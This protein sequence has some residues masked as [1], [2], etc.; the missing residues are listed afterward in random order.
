MA[1]ADKQAR[2]WRALFA[3]PGMIPTPPMLAGDLEPYMALS[4]FYA[5]AKLLKRSRRILARRLAEFQA[6]KASRSAADLRWDPTRERRPNSRRSATPAV[7][8]SA[9]SAH[10]RD[11]H[12]SSRRASQHQKIQDPR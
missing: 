11:R 2:L 3:L 4:A 10:A 9:S 8:A 5:A 1:S 7:Q 12:H 6:D